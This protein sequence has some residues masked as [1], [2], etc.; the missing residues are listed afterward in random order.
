MKLYKLKVDGMKTLKLFL[1][2]CALFSSATAFAFTKR[3]FICSPVES[4][5]KNP[6]V[7]KMEVIKDFIPRLSRI[8]LIKPNRAAT[9]F[10]YP[11]KQ[12][13]PKVSSRY[14]KGISFLKTKINDSIIGFTSIFELYLSKDLIKG[15]EQGNLVIHRLGGMNF[16]KLREIN[17]TYVCRER[18]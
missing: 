8:K 5:I 14:T 16:G 17:T 15:S 9:I 1:I 12:V 11:K 10:R 7:L 13:Q 4:N 3:T 18:S 2:T 6:P